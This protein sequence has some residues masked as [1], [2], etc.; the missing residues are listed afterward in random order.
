MVAKTDTVY[1]TRSYIGP[2]VKVFNIVVRHLSRTPQTMNC[3]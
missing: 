3:G 2:A 1:N